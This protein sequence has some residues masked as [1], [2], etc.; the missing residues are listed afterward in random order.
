MN[1][2]TFYNLKLTKRS[3]Y[4]ENR[5]MFKVPGKSSLYRKISLFRGSTVYDEFPA[6]YM[7]VGVKSL[8]LLIRTH[9]ES[10]VIE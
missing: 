8:I 6:L 1:L 3:F 5:E 9:Q 7:S 4:E 2:R 10:Y